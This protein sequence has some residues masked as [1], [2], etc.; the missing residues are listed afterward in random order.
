MVISFLFRD[1]L[2]CTNG[3]RS[4][5]CLGELIWGKKKEK[6]CR[7]VFQGMIIREPRIKIQIRIRWQLTYWLPKSKIHKD[8]G[9]KSQN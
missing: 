5:R 7:L 6:N 8:K 2:G 9:R 4:F 3:S 1:N